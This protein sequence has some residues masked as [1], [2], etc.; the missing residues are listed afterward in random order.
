MEPR[1]EYE[2]TPDG[3]GAIDWVR[4]GAARLAKRLAEVGPDQPCWTWVE[5]YP[6]T[7]FWA[8]RTANET[9]VH[10]WD[11]E[12]TAGTAGPID[13][14]LA[15]DGIAE[16]LEITR[17]GFLGPAPTGEGE[18]IHLHATDAPGE[19]LVR[20]DANGMHVTSEHSKGDVAIRG[21]ASDLLLVV[22]HRLPASTVDGFG[23]DQ[24][25]ARWLAKTAF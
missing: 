1:G 3:A 6:T 17:R 15:V 25:L 22:L 16:H 14:S 12:N 18:T 21:P 24:L 9:A 5:D 10:R 4:E 11:M 8:R 20:L 23:D 7:A 19:W 2:P 13:A